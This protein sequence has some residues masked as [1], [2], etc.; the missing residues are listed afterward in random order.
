MRDGSVEQTGGRIRL[1][2][3]RFLWGS[4]AVLA[5]TGEL[6]LWAAIHRQ[7]RGFPA[8]LRLAWLI[9]YTPRTVFLAFV[10]ASLLTVVVDFLVKILVD[11]PMRRWLAPR[12]DHEGDA[13]HGFG[14]HLGPTEQVLDQ[15]PGRL[16]TRPR[17]VPG[18]LILT[19]RRFWFVPS[20]W[21]AETWS[22]PRDQVRS[23]TIMPHAGFLGKFLRGVPPQL[24]LDAGSQAGPTTEF[25]RLDDLDSRS[26]P[27][28]RFALAEPRRVRSWFESEPSGA[29][30]R[31]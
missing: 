1:A 18:S 11:L 24:L 9:G 28:I 10:L 14:F 27:R 15:V 16:L 30:R 12:N 22:V 31:V 7:A 20:A 5:L 29:F 6:A 8:G 17:S 25:E 21:D 13:S 4:F 26:D 3:G 2:T 19:D 23:A